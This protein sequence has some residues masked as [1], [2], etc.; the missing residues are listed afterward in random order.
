[1]KLEQLQQA[2]RGEP[3]RPFMIHTTEGRKFRVPERGCVAITGPTALIANPELNGA[4]VEVNV[5]AIRS[6]EFDVPESTD[7]VD[8]RRPP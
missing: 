7:S 1:M 8:G 4:Y 2:L 5:S 6:V 3:F